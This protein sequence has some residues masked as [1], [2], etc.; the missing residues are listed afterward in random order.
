MLTALVAIVVETDTLNRFFAEAEQRCEN[1]RK[2]VVS[3][4]KMSSRS[5]Q[6]SWRRV[7]VGDEKRGEWNEVQYVCRRLV[8]MFTVIPFEASLLHVNNR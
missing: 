2:Q 1:L 8:L 5:F 6:V 7:A 3:G 4:A